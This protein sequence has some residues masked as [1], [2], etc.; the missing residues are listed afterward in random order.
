MVEPLSASL[1][2]LVV[3]AT[4]AEF[5]PFLEVVDHHA[6]VFG[7]AEDGKEIFLTFAPL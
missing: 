1:F 2:Q 6:F 3:L 4:F 5:F 7:C